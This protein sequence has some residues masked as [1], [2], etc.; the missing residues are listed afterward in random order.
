MLFGRYRSSS[1]DP[2]EKPEG[3]SVSAKG[4]ITVCGQSITKP[5]VLLGERSDSERSLAVDLLGE[6]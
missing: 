3:S 1:D 2:Q 5:D 4:L 6:G